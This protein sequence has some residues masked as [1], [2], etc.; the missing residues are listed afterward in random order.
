ML[1]MPFNSAGFRL[2]AAIVAIVL[3]TTH[4]AQSANQ[5]GAQVLT[6]VGYRDSAKVHR[7]PA[8]YDL[9][10]MSDGHIRVANRTTGDFTD[11]P[12][13]EASQARVPFTDNGWATFAWWFNQTNS[14]VS[15]FDTTWLVPPAPKTY[16]GQTLFQ[17][18]SI[19]PGDGTSILQPV[20]QYGPSAA[21]GG[22]YWAV[23]SWFVIGDNAYVT[24]LVEVYPKESL[25]GIIQQITRKRSLF[26]Y[27]SQIFGISG[28]E[29]IVR[30]IPELIWCTETLEVYGVDECTEFPNTAYSQMY[31]INV[32]LKRGTAPLA[33]SV[34]NAQTSCGVQTGV[35][36]N[37]PSNGVVNIYY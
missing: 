31:D 20:L 32:Q 33:W 6:P 26:S 4:M 36:V 9:N 2:A 37:G 27:S 34:T 3:P 14:P 30:N 15:Y 10:I 25:T 11:F 7:V 23:A 5:P 29:L 1:C 17:F 24:S 8:G 35:I 28:T 12:R 22:E 18:N 19:E 16:N 21:G 13:P